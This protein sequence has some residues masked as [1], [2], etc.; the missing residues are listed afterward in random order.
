M[1]EKFSRREL[2]RNAALLGAGSVALA[3]MPARAGVHTGSDALVVNGLD[4]SLLL[5]GFIDKLKQGGVHCVHKSVSGMESI[6]GLLAYVDDNPDVIALAK[7]VADIEGI[8]KSGRIALLMGS[9]EANYLEKVFNKR[10]FEY[11][12]KLRHTF[13]SYVELGIRVQGIA[14]NVTNIFGGGCLDPQV[15]LTR[16]GRVLVETIHNNN[17]IL[18]VGGHTGERTS[19]DAIEMS[20][21]VPVVC[22]HTNMAALNPNVR[23]ISDKLAEAIANTGGVI[24]ITAIS[25]FLV[26]SKASLEKYPDRSP[27]AQLD[28]FLD[29]YDHLKKL[30]GIDH[31]GLGPDFIWGWSE[32]LPHNPVDEVIF[33]TESL[34]EGVAQTVEGFEDISELPN[35]VFGL[36]D[37]GW[38]N[39]DLDKLLGLNWL[40]VYREVWGA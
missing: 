8:A 34:G 24:G 26:R 16:V 15:P 36:L 33:P 30:V 12:S 9:Q 38:S 20:K 14:Y 35:L 19:F 10:P 11:Y 2:F 29:Q 21:G 13:R 7:S 39:A 32:F 18:D 27:R 37:R 3:G 31:V 28:T 5:D 1:D 17:V 25:D 22:T 4:T 40:R 23:A 6:G